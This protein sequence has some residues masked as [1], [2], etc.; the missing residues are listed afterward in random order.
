MCTRQRLAEVR[1]F[2]KIAGILK[3]D[4][5]LEEAI[6]VPG[7]PCPPS[8][9]GTKFIAY[10]NASK[11]NDFLCWP[12]TQKPP[13]T[14]DNKPAIKYVT[15]STTPTTVPTPSTAV[16]AEDL[17]REVAKAIICPAGQ[18][19]YSVPPN[20]FCCLPDVYKNGEPYTSVGGVAV[21]SMKKI[22]T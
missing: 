4:Y 22:P 5:S 21:S 11:P 20:N 7:Q 3:E 15:K 16:Q 2:Q 13:T 10:T 19:L 1:R 17:V 18:S 6:P 14:I 8:S 12:A 9:D